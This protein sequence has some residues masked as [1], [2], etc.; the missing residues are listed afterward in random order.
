MT[1]FTYHTFQIWIKKGHRLYPY[2]EQMGVDA[3]G[4]YNVTNFYI[5]Q[6]YTSCRQDKPLQPLQQEVMNTLHQYIEAMNERQL[7]AY[8]A[9]IDKA[10][11]KPLLERR[12]IR[13]NLF[14]LPSK[15]R[16]L[17]GYNFLDCLFKV[18]KQK[19]YLAL[20][21]QSSQA[22][23]RLVCQNWKAFFASI[24]DYGQHPQKYTGKPRI[25]GYCRAREKE[26]L[27]SNQD[28]VI[29]E[30]KYLKLPKTRVRLNIGKLGCTDGK[31][32]Q[33]RV[34]PKY[35]QYVVELVFERSI[36]VE[37]RDKERFMAIDLGVDNLAT[38][39]TTTGSQPLL[40]KG[41]SIK[42]INQ[43]Y[44]KLKAHYTGILRQGK[45]PKEGPHTSKRLAQL[46]RNRQRRIKDLFHKAS[47]QIVK[48][49]I[50]QNIGTIV[51]GKND[52][53][54][55]AVSIGR[56]NNQSF[57][58]IPHHM[59][60]AMIRYKA[61]EQGIAVQ[62][63]EEAYTSKASFLDHDPVPAYE[64]GRTRSFS[65]RRI[66][67]GLYRSAKGL[68]NADVNGAANILRKVVPNAR[69]NG[70]AG[71]DGNQSV[72]VSTPQVLSIR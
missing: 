9:K 32:K 57:C 33:V 68:I 7:A 31:L 13:C 10:Q 50:E 59:L 72:N 26:M 61:A 47:Y 69:A 8:Q 20:S 66:G 17:V 46:H 12:E 16:P 37:A 4:L 40:V 49:A 39:V 21:I 64:E 22:V 38:L 71:L 54:K 2:F 51:M 62:L 70:I 1:D 28:C 41:K 52:G 42:A 15:V 14:E 53:W 35:G 58:H 67:R 45:A 25:P 63:T 36:A 30:G 23:M 19:D 5:R 55:Q 6:I 3:K 65:G 43:Y 60:I 29:Q 27:F 44:N 18:M 34:V 48:Q 24:K 56:R 11:L